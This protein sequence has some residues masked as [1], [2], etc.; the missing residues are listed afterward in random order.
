[1]SKLATTPAIEKYRVIARPATY[2]FGNL[3][4]NGCLLFRVQILFE[5]VCKPRHFAIVPRRIPTAQPY[6]LDL[7]MASN[8]Y[9]P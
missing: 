9:C 6:N 2:G 4:L 3:P 8:H 7:T 5:V 1:M